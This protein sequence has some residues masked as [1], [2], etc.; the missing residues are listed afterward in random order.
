MGGG[1]YSD[2]NSMRRRVD[3]GWASDNLVRSR[4][5]MVPDGY[6]TKT[7]AETFSQRELHNDMNPHGVMVRESRDSAEHPES[8]AILI[9]MDETGSMGMVP[10]LLVKEGLPHLMN[11]IYKAGIQHPQVLF[12]GIGD[13]KC[14]RA[15]LQIGQYETSD[16][17]LDKWLT[18]TYLEGGGGGNGGESY[19]LAWYFAGFRTALDCHEKRGQ[20]GVLITVGDEACHK[21]YD[22]E[23]LRS[24]F[25]GK[26][27]FRT[28]SSQEMLAAAREK[29]HVFHVLIHETQEGHRQS[30]HDGWKELM[31][32]NLLIAE[33]HKDVPR[34]ITEAVLS[35]VG[36][37]AQPSASKPSDAV[38]P[39]P[40]KPVPQML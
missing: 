40:D 24:I 27:E 25:G 16:E 32:D 13:H 5:L 26:A 39:V 33:T 11:A 20:K 6:R 8:L 4:K 37:T 12:A 34:L 1:S 7:A 10:D 31:G 35:V 29:Y 23:A 30:T 19:A 36:K 21:D 15:P 17:L 2:D 38:T 3:K 22:G 14:D 9:A 18:S 28:M